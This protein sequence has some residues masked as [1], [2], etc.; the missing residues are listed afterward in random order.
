VSPASVLYTPTFFA[1]MPQN[2]SE[3]AHVTRMVAQLRAT[4]D[5]LSVA[6]ARMDE[7]ALRRQ[8]EDAV[9]HHGVTCA[10]CGLCPVVGVRYKCM[11]CESVD[12]CSAC[13]EARAHDGAHRHPLFLKIRRPL[14]VAHEASWAGATAPDCRSSGPSAGPAVEP[15]AVGAMPPSYVLRFVRDVTI[16][17]GA[18]VA[19][20]ACF[21]KVWCV[22]NIGSV[23]W[24]AD[25]FLCP[26]N[27]SKIE[28]SAVRIPVRAARPGEQVDVA[29]DL[30]APLTAGTYTMECRFFSEQQGWQRDMA[31]VWV[32]I[33]VDGQACIGAAVPADAATRS[34][35]STAPHEHPEACA[36]K[37]AH[38]Q[39]PVAA[40]SAS[41]H[42]AAEAPPAPRSAQLAELAT[43]GNA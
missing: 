2:G 30:R 21:T 23:A 42:A 33:R 14:R 28:Y 26:Q 32:T 29:I 1:D 27:G 35:A 5:D 7:Q 41:A 25:L 24:P 8:H 39:P 34:V 9:A 3:L 12:L 6:V 43:M 38:V 36:S 11:N 40:A 31:F 10:C 37:Q 19:P 13:E 15:A 17:D 20:G 4:V 18:V 22:E 16:E